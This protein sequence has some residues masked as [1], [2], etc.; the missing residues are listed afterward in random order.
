[1]NRA[2]LFDGPRRMRVVTR[3]DPEVGPGNALIQIQWA[4]ICGSDIDVRNGTRPAEAVRYPIVPGHEWSGYVEAIGDGVD[5]ELLHQPVVGEN[6]RSCGVCA[7]CR[8]GAVASCGGA[9]S[10]AGFTIDGAWADRMLVP[11]SSLYVLPE[12]ADL[13][14]AAGIEP[15]ACAATA[16]DRASV[17]P[18]QRVGVIGG[19]T[20]GMLCTQLLSSRRA[21]VTVVD[22]RYWRRPIAI[23][24]GASQYF[25]STTARSSAG[26]L[27]IVFEAAG[28][29]GSAQM[30]VDLVRRGGRVIVCG[31][32]PAQDAVRS[33]DIVAKNLTVVG[34][35]GATKQGWISAVSEFV[36]GNL[37]PGMLVTHEFALLEIES[38]LNTVES[39]GPSVGKVLIRT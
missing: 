28:V 29:A 20:I 1:M 27:D 32:A 5:P 13:R 18:H 2:V 39:A 8:V 16:V 6:I 31:I 25:D 19:G 30:A 24:C 15:A 35:F 37:D 4:G 34:I 3:P 21:D 14:S 22:P 36:S 33:I 38:A 11:A 23:Q 17:E 9:Y 26:D 10:E 7:S 12:N